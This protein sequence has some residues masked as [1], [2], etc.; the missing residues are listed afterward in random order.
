MLTNILPP[1]ANLIFVGPG[2]FTQNGNVLLGSL[3]GLPMGGSTVVTI[4]MT[5][6]NVDA[7]LTFDA[8]VAAAEADL[9]PGN[10]HVSIK[11]TVSSQTTAVPTLFAARK[12]GQ[13][14]LSWQGTSTD[15]VLQTVSQLG[16]AWS[17]TGSAPVVSNG[18]STVTVPINAGAKFFRLRR[19]P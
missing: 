7:L 19:V 16:G 11:T 6:P 18:V 4:T 9:N 15:V 13:L 10:N 1:G 2:S 8:T 17:T 3:G 12:N 14:V 5:A